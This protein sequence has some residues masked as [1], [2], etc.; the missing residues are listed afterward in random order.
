MINSNTPRI[1]TVGRSPQNDIVINNNNVSSSHAR[2][3]ISTNEIILE[4]V[5]STNGTYI[6]GEKITSQKVTAND[7]ITFSK[8]HT[9]DWK[10]LD[11]LIKTGK[12]V[13]SGTGQ[14]VH[15]KIKERDVITIGRSSDNDLVINNIKVSRKHAKLEKSGNEWFVED[16][17]SSNGTFLNGEKVKRVK[18]TPKDVLT[19]GG[20]PLNIEKLFAA[21]KEIKGDI[22]IAANNITFRVK[23]K[24]IVDEVGLTILPGEF[25]GLIGPSGAGKTSLMMMMNGVVRPSQGD[26]FINSQSLYSNF[27]LFKGQIG[28]VPQDD[29]IHRELKVQESFTY[30][31]KLR[32]DNYSNEEIATQVDTV[33]D[34]LG[35]EDTRDTLIG[36]AEKKG[37]SGGQR[38]RVN[39]G[40][41]LLTEPSVLF[42]DEPTSGLDPKTD[43]DV[44]HLFKGIAAKGKII[45]LTTH[46]ITKEN[47]DIL[48]HLIVLSKGGKLAYFGEANKAAD[49]FQ[50]D[51][52][53][54]IFGKLET[55]EP[56]HWKE[57][58]IKSPEYK[59][60][61]AAREESI[62]ESK[63]T[64]ISAPPSRKAD[65]KQF[66]TLTERFFR[67]K[68]RDRVSTAILLL[69][70]PI[71]AILIALVF[72]EAT[73]KT[74]ALFILVIAAVWLG[75]S[76]AAREIVSEQAIFK[77]ERMVNLK[78]PSYLF[79]KV[80]VLMLLCVVQC[81]ILAMIVVPAINMESSFLSIFFLLLLTSLPSLLLGLFVSSLVSTSEAAMGLIPLILIPQVVLGGLITFFANM[82]AFEKVIAAFLT[83]RWAFEGITI[84]E[85]GN[86]NEMTI[87]ELGFSPGNLFTDIVVILV[88]SVIFFL[89]TAYSLKRKDVR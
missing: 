76:N 13:K 47:F 61:V 17:G 15:T 66:L 80:A 84:L 31:G 75:C 83:T 27:D 14:R 28:Y 34:T 38:K 23:D 39:L 52:P 77:R 25:V 86:F 63:P 42:L 43:L 20:I 70:A 9:F 8:T 68:L 3:K 40:Q 33:L 85:Y 48:S 55:N 16:L 4:D 57:K 41:E 71:I 62:L 19:I 81:A 82:S 18:V 56:D 65:M 44:M 50:V 26:V 5:G 7:T 49:Y 12:P 35:I 2:F 37:I 78:I 74:A 59:K 24:L 54:E 21:E 10:L 73:E 32:L 22:Q 29:I 89:L 69:Q 45:I 87:S 11:E 46:N 51:K 36:S 60:F 30:T 53:Y 6:N 58:F 64:E 1:I 72:D 67:V 79:S 88:F